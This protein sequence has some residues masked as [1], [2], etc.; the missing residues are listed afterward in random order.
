MATFGYHQGCSVLGDLWL[1]SKLI[2]VSELIKKKMDHK[3]IVSRSLFSYIRPSANLSMLLS[4]QLAGDAQQSCAVLA[5]R[6]PQI[7]PGTSCL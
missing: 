2:D 5:R 6:A 1:R 7:R 3:H 4:S